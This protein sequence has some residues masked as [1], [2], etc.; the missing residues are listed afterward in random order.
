MTNLKEWYRHFFN[1]FPLADQSTQRDT[2]REVR[3]I[4]GQLGL[5]RGQKVLDLGCGV[6]RHAIPLA[7]KGVSVTGLDSTASYLRMA[8]ERADRASLEVR[9]IEGDMRRIPYK[10][11]FDAVINCWTS[12]GYFTNP[13][14]DA[15]VLKE[16]RKSLKPGGL[17]FLD[18]VNGERVLNDPSERDWSQSNSTYVLQ[19]TDV[20]KGPDPACVTRWVFIKEG[21]Q[22]REG[23]SFTRL[24]TKPRLEKLLK[25]CGFKI[26]KAWGGYD[27]RGVEPESRRL[28]VLAKRA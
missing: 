24:Y 4:L 10:D 3:F 19:E 22:I 1:L 27:G 17:L 11:E 15:R 18:V 9:W 8:R 13:Q 20:R 28:M 6:G 25:S 12:F 26:L 14:D 5:R 2:D 16:A 7:Q 21:Q 23:H